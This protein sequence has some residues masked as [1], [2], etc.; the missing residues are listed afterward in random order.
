ANFRHTPETIC[1]TYFM[2]L[3]LQRQTYHRLIYFINDMLVPGVDIYG[4]VNPFTLIASTLTT[5]TET[6]LPVFAVHFP[7]ADALATIFSNI[8][9][10]HFLQED[11]ALAS[12]A[13]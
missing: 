4:T 1:L 10:A 7:S 2:D 12:L 6:F 13:Q 9:S 3:L 11:S 5:T 8:L